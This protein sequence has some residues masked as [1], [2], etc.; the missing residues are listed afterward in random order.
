ME[1]FRPM[2]RILA[3]HGQQL[4]EIR[5]ALARIETALQF[6]ISKEFDMSAE[7][8]TL[9][10]QVKANSDAVDSATALINGI[11]ARI[12][13]AVAGGAT[14]ATLAAMTALS[15]E[16]KAKDDTLAAAVVA[17]TPAAPAP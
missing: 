7:L 6:S 13:A 14:Q 10:A 8:D 17:N 4:C 11:A 3:E 5:A 12:D 2:H 1:V 15:S 16:L 9:T